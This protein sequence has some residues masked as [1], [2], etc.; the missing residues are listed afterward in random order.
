VSDVQHDKR[1]ASVFALI[2]EALRSQRDSYWQSDMVYGLNE[3][4]EIVE[5]LAR[6]HNIHGTGPGPREV[7]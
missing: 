5:C 3:A 7:V 2:L 6:S 4:I 1:Q